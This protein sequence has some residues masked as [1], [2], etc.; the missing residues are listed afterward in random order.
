MRRH[1]PLATVLFGSAALFTAPSHAQTDGTWLNMG[2][3]QDRDGH[4]A[5]YDAARD[6]MI[7]FSGVVGSTRR[8]DV[9]V[10]PLSSAAGWHQMLVHGTPPSARDDHAAICDPAS[11]RMNVFGGIDTGYC[12]DVWSLSPAGTPSWQPI[13]PE[14][15]PCHGPATPPSTTRCGNA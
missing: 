9:W 6:C 7:A 2:L 4:S 14:G 13:V 1:P 15:L 8:N 12:N 3:P 11:D 10:L 5:V